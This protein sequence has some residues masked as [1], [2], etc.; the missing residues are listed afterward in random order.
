[1]TV[2]ALRILIV[3]DDVAYQRLLRRMLGQSCFP[4]SVTTTSTAEEF[5]EALRT[6]AF[7]CAVMDFNLGPTD[8]VQVIERAGD[9]LRNI[10]IIVVSSDTRQRVVVE[11]MRHGVTDFFRKSDLATEQHLVERILEVVE[12]AR[13]HQKERRRA[14]RRERRLLREAFTDPLTK[15]SNRRHF[16]HMIETG[17]FDNDRRVRTA[18]VM[19]DIDRF[20]GINDTHG[21]GFGDR[22]IQRVAGVLVDFTLGETVFRWGGEEFLVLRSSAG[23]A[24]DWIWAEDIR[25]A[26]EGEIIRFNGF[27]VPVTISVGLHIAPT[28]ELGESPIARA[29]EALYLAKSLGRNRVCTSRMVRV[30]DLARAVQEGGGDIRTRRDALLKSLGTEVGPVQRCAATDHSEQ[31]CRLAEEI[32]R[33]MNLNEADLETLRQS[34]LLHDIGKVVMPEETLAKPFALDGVERLIL[35]RRGEIGRELC[36]M[37]GVDAGVSRIVGACPARFDD[38]PNPDE[39][40]RITRILV[41][42]DA[43]AAMMS[44]RTYAPAR[45]PSEA[46][47]ELRRG[48]GS[49]FDPEVISAVHRIPAVSTARREAA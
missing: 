49:S 3:E 31:V 44:D 45:Q 10:P 38:V 36:G 21:H 8:A 15:L 20:K 28:H 17:Y 22:V 7:D 48:A 42:A 9:A 39:T 2:D 35:A 25:R 30:G 40:A 43:L 12:A 16:D 41:V 5:L 1:M 37:M 19:V 14:E 47:D 6:D 18:C 24:A 27:R 11:S 32:G 4:M 29:D 46:L 33:Q 13:D 34:A 26:V 23:E